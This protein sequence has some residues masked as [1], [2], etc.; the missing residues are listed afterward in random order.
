[1]SV[2]KPISVWHQQPFE[3]P[4]LRDDVALAIVYY[5]KLGSRKSIRFW[6]N[7]Y[8]LK[9]GEAFGAVAILVFY[10]INY[11]LLSKFHKSANESCYKA[12]S[13][14]SLI[15]VL[16]SI[17][18]FYINNSAYHSPKTFLALSLIH[19]ITLFVLW[20][21]KDRL[22]KIRQP[23]GSFIKDT[24]FEAVSKDDKA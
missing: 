7:I 12:K 4:V 22:I 21:L 13:L 10:L 18:I 16:L 2:S 8:L 19:I 20:V 14:G 5:R 11:L 17:S 9:K 3:V 15:L 1:M 23:L 6:K 24:L